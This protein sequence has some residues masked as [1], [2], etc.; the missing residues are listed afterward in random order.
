MS[1]SLILVPA[2]LAAVTAVSAAGGAGILSLVGTQT[3]DEEP[4]TAVEESGGGAQPIQVQ[5]RM[6]D[7]DLL[8]DALRDLGATEVTVGAD[9]IS[10]VVDDLELSMTRTPDGVW[11]AHFQRLDGHELA[12]SVAADVVARLDAAYALRVQQA[13]AARI[14]DRADVAGFELV[15]E[16]RDDEDTVTMVLTVKE[17]A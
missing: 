9:E 3:T 15:S 14:R 4:H 8:G 11:A 13:V 5:T 12:E 2:A 16:T 10:A 7:P 6:K 1:V 17:Y